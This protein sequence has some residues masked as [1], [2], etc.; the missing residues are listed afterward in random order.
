MRRGSARPAAARVGT[1]HLAGCLLLAWSAMLLSRLEVEAAEAEVREARGG[2]LPQLSS[3]SSFTRDIVSTNPF[4][5]TRA[6]G[7]PGGAA[8]GGAAGRREAPPSTRPRGRR[9]V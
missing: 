5:G 4:A 1:S 3:G 8:R 2:L 9:G 7:E 6:L